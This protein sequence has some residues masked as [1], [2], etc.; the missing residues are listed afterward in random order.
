MGR[1]VW[2][3]RNNAVLAASPLDAPDIAAE[4]LPMVTDVLIQCRNVLSLAAGA[5][6]EISYVRVEDLKAI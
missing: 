4:M 2:G 1:Y 6:A 3:S 5:W